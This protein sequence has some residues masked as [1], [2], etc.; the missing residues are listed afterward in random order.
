[1]RIAR[2]AVLLATVATTSFI[3]ISVQQANAVVALS[4]SA[5]DAY[6]LTGADVLVIDSPAAFK[7]T[8]ENRSP[9]TFLFLYA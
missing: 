4:G 7:I 3:I 2:I 1:M 5:D 9:G 8:F 6:V